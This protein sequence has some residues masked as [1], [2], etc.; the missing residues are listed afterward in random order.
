MKRRSGDEPDNDYKDSSSKCPDSS[1][2]YRGTVRENI[3][4]RP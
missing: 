1:E 3:G 2:Q 4:T